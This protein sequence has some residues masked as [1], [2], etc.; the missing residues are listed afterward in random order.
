[1]PGSW[2]ESALGAGVEARD[3]YLAE[4]T[5]K[6]EAK[7]G[8]II[9][10]IIILCLTVL[11]AGMIVTSMAINEFVRGRPGTTRTRIVQALIVSDLILGIVGLIS[12]ALTLSGDGHRIQH[13][14]TA[15]SGLGFMLTTV[16]WS[17]HLWTLILAFATYMILI[18]PLHSFTLWLERRWYFLW[19]LVWVIST[20]I[21]LVGFEV[22]GYYPAGG[23]CYYGDNTGLYAEL[24]QFIP[25]AVVCLTVVIL[26]SRLIVFLRR[27]DKIR[28]GGSGSTTGYLTQSETTQTRRL[29]RLVMLANVFRRQPSKSTGSAEKEVKDVNEV[30]IE[31]STPVDSDDTRRPSRMTLLPFIRSQPTSPTSTPIPLSDLPPWERIELPPFQVDGER[32]GGPQQPT[33]T[34]NSM[35]SG[36][37]GLGGKKRPSTGSVISSKFQPKSRFG[38]VSSAGDGSHRKESGN[39]APTS[40]ALLAHVP[41]MQ[42]ISA[43]QDDTFYPIYEPVQPVQ[44]SELLLRQEH[45]EAEALSPTQ[46]VPPQQARKPSSSA[47]MVDSVHSA[48]KPLSPGTYFPSNQAW[49]RTSTPTIERQRPSVSTVVDDLDSGE[50]SRKSSA[51]SDEKPQVPLLLHHP[52]AGHA[53]PGRPLSPVISQ[54]SPASRPHSPS[55][56]FSNLAPVSTPY[57]DSR[58]PQSQPRQA[59]SSQAE[60]GNSSSSCGGK[61]MEDEDEEMDLMKMLAGPPPAHMDDRF[62]PN[63]SQSGEQYELVPESMSSYLNRK[64]ALLMLWFPLGYVILFSVSFIR[65]IYDFAGDPPTALRAISRWFVLSQG[66]LDAIIYGFVE[67]HTKRVVRRRVR[68]GTYPPQDTG[69]YSANGM[70]MVG[71]AARVVQGF[72][73]RMTGQG[74]NG[75]GAGV[76]SKRGGLTTSQQGTGTGS[77]TGRVSFTGVQSHDGQ[78]GP[79]NALGLTSYHEEEQM[80]EG[81]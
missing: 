21:G 76:G 27:P 79:R 75:G 31:P 3:V 7:E 30:H 63:Q 17:E 80:S 78:R 15:C 20:M 54:A 26:Y 62:A 61:V 81:R 53:T 73:T 19:G 14:T 64:T 60:M 29:S 2:A 39:G 11:G 67:W 68:K 42:S 33:G 5:G 32:F 51:P 48:S 52:N 66:L 77:Q 10:N 23:V 71:N 38:S 18:Y 43:S 28:A 65:L 22:W 46:E 6:V 56:S 47:T 69:S 1:M 25:R 44:V 35:W 13:G 72:A 4:Q 49:N 9:V 12:G 50:A 70:K 41:R 16:L 57:D 36:W 74:S 45:Q 8:I 24:I 37:K 58:V 40:P 55:T 59:T 34:S